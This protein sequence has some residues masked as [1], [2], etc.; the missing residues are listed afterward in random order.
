MTTRTR[1]AAFI[2]ICLFVVG[3]TTAYLV[4]RGSD[5]DDHPAA[6][7]TAPP[8]TDMSSVIDGPR[9]VFRNS[10]IGP[11]YGKIA[12]VALS[13]PAGPRALLDTTCDRVSATPDATI[14]LQSLGGV[15]STYTETATNADGAELYSA[16]RTE[17]PAGR[18]CRPM[19]AFLPP[20][21]SSP[22]TPTSARASPPA[23]TSL[24]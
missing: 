14:C 24:T 8:T 13:D 23:L 22:A 5:G 11:D 12:V 2:A 9:I 18:G 4:S 1:V 19:G 16:N 6:A 15:T 21:A 7:M 3:G 17:F 20:R 10:V